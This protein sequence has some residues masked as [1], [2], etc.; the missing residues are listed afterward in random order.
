[1]HK[2]LAE[3]MKESAMAVLP[4]GAIILIL[5]FFVVPLPGM[6]LPMMLTGMFMLFL[7]MS[8][9]SIGVDMAMMPI[10]QH[11]GSALIVSRN[12]PLIVG[13]LFAFGF[14]VTIA[15][16]DLSVLARQVASIP[17]TT[18]LVAISVGVGLFLV[19]AVLRILFHWRLSRLLVIAYPIAFIIAVFSSDYLAVAIDSAALTTGPVTVPF[20]LAI[21]SGFAAVSSGKSA[22][23]DN[24]G[25]SA[26]CSVGPI[27]SVLLLGTFFDSSGTQYIA[28]AAE[29]VTTYGAMAL[30]FL[31]SLWHALGEIAMIIAPIVA[32]FILFQVIKLKLSRT[33]LIRIFVGLVYLLA[34]I[35]IFFAGVNKGFLPAAAAL[36]EELGRLN[37][38]WIL[39]PIAFVIGLGV[40]LAEPTVYVLTN[41][42]RDITNG[43]ISRRLMLSGMAAGVGVAMSLSI[44]RILFG[45]SIWWILIPGYIIS[46][47][48]SFFAPGMFV[49]IGFDSGGVVT[50]AM[51]AAFVVP[52]SIGVC[53]VIPGRNIVADAFG[54]AGVLAMVAPI[55]IQLLGIS[56]SRKLKKARLLDAQAVG[57]SAE[58]AEA[59]TETEAAEA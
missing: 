33:E 40:V 26:I 55:M 35:T 54:T 30:M 46:L 32:V 28:Q 31:D 17:D 47:S 2:V 41:Q 58:E 21:G 38:N 25:I 34:G 9:F 11:V 5:H 48:L 10:G 20:L 53:S 16:P 45:F 44:T 12:L 1:M 23:E 57:H 56:Y 4:I 52:F 3:K 50:G 6:T 18:L 19:L 37:N 14:V 36:G 51:T 8:L 59:G 24:F 39:I 15:E 22:D 43:A 7:G 27:L 13:V 49:G 29:P 42:V